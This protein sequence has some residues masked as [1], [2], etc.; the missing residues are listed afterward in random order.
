MLS[1]DRGD[2][3]AADVRNAKA[4]SD[5]LF[6]FSSGTTGMPKAVRHT[7][8]VVRRTRCGTGVIALTCRRPTGMQIMTPPSHILGCSTS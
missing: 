6:V 7:Q 3:P 1:L 5:A 2:T 4:P 8:R